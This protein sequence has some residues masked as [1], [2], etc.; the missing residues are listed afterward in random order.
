MDPRGLWRIAVACLRVAPWGNQMIL[1]CTSPLLHREPGE[2]IVCV[3]SAVPC[4]C[5]GALAVSCDNAQDRRNNKRC[6]WQFDSQPEPERLAVCSLHKYVKPHK[7]RINRTNMQLFLC[8]N[9]VCG[10]SALA[11][12]AKKAGC[13]LIPTDSLIRFQSRNALPPV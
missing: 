11:N 5:C 2:E 1:F 13:H 9:V 12:I 10:A 4:P 8:L 6:D 7:L 3:P